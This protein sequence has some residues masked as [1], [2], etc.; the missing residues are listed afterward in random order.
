ANASQKKITAGNQKSI[1]I[2]QLAN[3]AFILLHV[4]SNHFLGRRHF[5]FTA[6]ALTLPGLVCS[7]VLARWGKP[8]FSENGQVVSSGEDLSGEGGLIEHMWDI[9]YVTW[10]CLTMTGF[11]GGIMW[12]MFIIVPGFAI[13]K[14]ASFAM[15]FL[16]PAAG[17][18]RDAIS[19]QPNTAEPGESKRQQKLKQR[20]QK[21]QP[22]KRHQ[23]QQR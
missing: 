21:G 18:M 15:P 22:G 8:V 10:M 5:S 1:R 3:A 12:W 6:L 9:V 14:A 4:I 20:Q 23:Q 17:R 7:L 13:F 2:L 11:F 16:M 19:S